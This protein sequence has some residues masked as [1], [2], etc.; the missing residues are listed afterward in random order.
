MTFISIPESELSDEDEEFVVI[1]GHVFQGHEARSRAASLVPEPMQIKSWRSKDIL[2]DLAEHLDPRPEAED[3]EEMN[4]FSKV[5][6]YINVVPNL[7]FK[8]TIPLNEMSW[9]KPLTLL[10]AFTCPAFLLFSIQCECSKILK[11]RLAQKRIG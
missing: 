9:S 8:L 5:M 10:H 2:K 3:W 1:H 7:L 11:I 6:A 4:I